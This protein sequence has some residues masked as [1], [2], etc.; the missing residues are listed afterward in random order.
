MIK[1]IVDEKGNQKRLVAYLQTKFNKMPQNAIYKALRN[2]D[3]KINGVRTKENV[4][5]WLGDEL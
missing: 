5:L 2:K 3:I 1:I 4:T